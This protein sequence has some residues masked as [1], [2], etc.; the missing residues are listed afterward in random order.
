MSN[1]QINPNEPQINPNKPQI[2]TDIVL[3]YTDNEIGLIKAT[4]NKHTI[5]A[6]R[7]YFLQGELNKDEKDIIKQFS[8]KKDAIQLLRDALTPKVDV[9]KEIDDLQD[10]WG[11]VD[12]NTTVEYANYDMEARQ[13]SVDY[14]EELFNLLILKEYTGDYKIKLI[15]LIY[16]RDNTPKDNYINLRARNIYIIQW[17]EFIFK[18][19]MYFY[20]FK[21]ETEEEQK[22]REQKD[23]AE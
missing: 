4:F 7:K 3:R 11:G 6:L 17:I 1:Q 22:E 14:F 9:N 12:L 8:K 10:I 21:K 15:N 2:I 18:Q 13:I 23:S 20:N 19:I 16:S 5:M